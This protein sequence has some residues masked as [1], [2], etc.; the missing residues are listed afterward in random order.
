MLLRGKL[1]KVRQLQ[2]YLHNW[3]LDLVV[4]ATLIEIAAH[5]W[6][7]ATPA[8]KATAEILHVSHVIIL[9]LITFYALLFL[10]FWRRPSGEIAALLKPSRASESTSQYCAL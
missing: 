9:V 6:P 4:V 10:F 1:E 5:Y 3:V 8:E 7:D 2:H